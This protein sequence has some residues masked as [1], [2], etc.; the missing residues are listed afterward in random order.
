M[1]LSEY[2]RLKNEIKYDVGSSERNKDILVTLKNIFKKDINSPRKFEQIVTIGELLEELETRDALS[3]NNLKP[4]EVIAQRLP[5]NTQFLEKIKD[6]EG[7]HVPRKYVNYYGEIL[8]LIFNLVSF[9]LD[10]TNFQ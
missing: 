10:L 1:T 7:R 2:M 8:V 4:L 9:M 6:Y 5:N 3:E